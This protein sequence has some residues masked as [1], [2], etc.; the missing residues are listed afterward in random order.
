MLG[1]RKELFKMGGIVSSTTSIVI[2]ILGFIV[3][4]SGW[5]LLTLS[6]NIIPAKILPN[7]IDV[8]KS[9]G[10]LLTDYDLLGNA[11]YTIKINSYG[12]LIAVLISL[13]IG[14]V[15]GIFPFFHSLLCKYIDALR[16]L[17]L[18][19]VTG[20]FICWLG[21]GIQMKVSFLAFGIILFLLPIIIQ[22][23]SDLQ[24]SAN[25]KSFVFLQTIE[26][27][28]AN[29]WHKFKYVYFPFVVET[30]IDNLR[31]IGAISYTY[32]IVAEVLNREGGLG[33]SIYTLSRQSRMPEVFAILFVII[34]IGILQDF[35]F[36]HIDKIVIPWKYNK[37]SIFKKEYVKNQSNGKSYSKL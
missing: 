34:A 37:N 17:P 30:F 6:G 24:N 31:V 22:R 32:T 33:A 29:N 16:F 35:I 27:L 19:A 23:I 4:L 11:L 36:K 14:M 10:I 25:E 20:L 5:Y 2:S 21:I 9:Y 13:P 7:P 12:L 15:I 8:I 28:G 18:T 1:D 3:L 26:T